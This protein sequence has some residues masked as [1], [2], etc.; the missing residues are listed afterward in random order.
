MKR[1]L[2]LIAVAALAGAVVLTGCTT[3][4]SSQPSSTD[5][6]QL[7]TPGTLTV[8]THLP[9]EPMESRDASGT[10]VGFDF[11]LMGLV[12]THLGLTVT[13]VEVDPA[14]MTS[15]AAMIA[16][17]CDISAEGMTITD[18]R[19][20]AVNFSVPY[21]GVTQTLAV[22]AS[23]TVTSLADLKG[24]NLGVEAASTGED[25]ATTNQ[26]KYGYQQVSFD[27][28]ATLL[29]SL[30]TGRSDAVLFDA[31]YVSTFVNQNQG[32]KIATQIVTGEVY[33]FA[34]ARNASGGA[35]IQI[36]DQ[37]LQTANTDGTYLSIYKKWIDPNATSASLPTS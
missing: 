31:G 24:K 8:C 30:L 37:V 3:N 33:G 1:P 17:K 27:D 32:V 7:V 35:L 2:A 13:A 19:A 16:M 4:P 15:G 11:D 12:A 14:Q 34:T 22:P 26:D 5:G 6:V 36:V 9:F 21:F 25:Y 10:V 23:S 20:Q 18:A 29:N 28:A